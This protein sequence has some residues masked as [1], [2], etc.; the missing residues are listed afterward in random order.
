MLHNTNKHAQVG[1]SGL[2]MMICMYA[3]VCPVCVCMCSC[4]FVCVMDLLQFS[5]TIQCYSF[6]VSVAEKVSFPNP[7]VCIFLN[8]PQ[9]SRM[10]QQSSTNY[11]KMS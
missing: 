8:L 6:N 9:V 7:N 4:V 1:N 11:R 3:N 2:H 5:T 10:L